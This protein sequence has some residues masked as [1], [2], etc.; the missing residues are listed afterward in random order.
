MIA[1][2]VLAFA[3]A[4][5]YVRGTQGMGGWVC[6]LAHGA[7]RSECYSDLFHPVRFVQFLAPRFQLAIRRCPKRD[8]LLRWV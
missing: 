2:F 1:R 6:T 7:G 3:A 5:G 4:D 8:V